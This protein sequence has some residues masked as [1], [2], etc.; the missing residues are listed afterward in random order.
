MIMIP[1]TNSLSVATIDDDDFIRV[2]N[3]KWFLK[4]SAYTFY[5]CTCIKINGYPKIIRLHRFIMNAKK[6]EEIH[7]KDNNPL[8]NEKYNLERHNSG[9]I[10][11]KLYH[12]N[13]PRDENGRYSYA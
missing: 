1:L 2:N 5:V 11:I 9:S 12:N 8:V 4:Q 13:K 7:H 3:H 10:H 6:G